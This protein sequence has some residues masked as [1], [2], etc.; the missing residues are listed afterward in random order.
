MSR[1]VYG[2]SMSLD[3]FVAGPDQS[4]DHPL[5][6]GGE[7]LH[8]WM[9]ALAAWR[10]MAGEE[11]GETNASTAVFEDGNDDVGAIIMGRNM[12]GGGPGSWGENAWTGWWG[13]NP[14]FHLPVFVLTH[15]QRVPLAMQGGTT[16]TFVT[17]GAGEALELARRAADGKDVAVSGGGSV[18]R[19][20]LAAGV[21]DDLEIHL[22]PVFLGAGVRLFD[23][24]G[25]A[26]VK[27]EQTR[28]IEAPGVT[29]LK[30]RIIR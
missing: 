4:V 23:G 26:A 6:V 11:G 3:G 22:V 7:L 2:V 9:R 18:G 16:F 14:P 5:G 28:V 12:F 8:E 17:G 29:H 13:D 1:V 30:Y 27:L 24:P 15:H 21:L 20:Y 10:E 19:Q 25:L